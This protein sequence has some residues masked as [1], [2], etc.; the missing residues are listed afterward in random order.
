MQI[1]GLLL[2]L[3]DGQVPWRSTTHPGVYWFGLHREPGDGP[4]DTTVLIRM[5]P[6]C[7]YPVHRHEGVEEVLVLSGGF[8]D[9]FGLHSAG[10]Y[11]R[12]D[13]GTRHS[14]L[15]IGD[16]ARPAGGQN[17]PC[18]LF[19]VARGGVQLDPAG[20]TSAAADGHPSRD[21]GSPP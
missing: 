9:E 16:P 21:V 4:R 8:R 1:P 15:A 11:V 19:S 18:V 5:D 6:G 2:E 7:G 17:V 20:G 14:P 12:Y 10:S 13:A 3:N